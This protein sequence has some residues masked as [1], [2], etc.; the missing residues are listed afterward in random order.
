MTRDSNL[1]KGF[2]RYVSQKKKVKEPH[3]DEHDNTTGKLVTTDEEKAEVL[4]KIFAS[5]FTVILSFHTSQVYGP[6]DGDWGSKVP[7]TVREDVMSLSV[8]V[9]RTEETILNLLL[10]YVSVYLLSLMKF[11]CLKQNETRVGT[12]D[13]N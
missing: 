13:E 10:I 1:K 6:Q 9:S 7:P 5:F 3:L 2:Y 4:S 8:Y 12:Q 11:Q